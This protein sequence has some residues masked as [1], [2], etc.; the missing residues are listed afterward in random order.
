MAHLSSLY[1]VTRHHCIYLYMSKYEK[2][3]HD[4]FAYTRICQT[5]NMKRYTRIYEYIVY[6]G[7]S[8]YMPVYDGISF[9]NKVYT[10]IYNANTLTWN[11]DA[12]I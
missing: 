1:D 6:D 11:V 4:I 10:V 3:S 8:W 5:W 9:W 7:I 12:S 2:L